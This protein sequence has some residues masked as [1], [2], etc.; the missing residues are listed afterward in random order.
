MKTKRRYQKRLDQTTAGQPETR[1]SVPDGAHGL[2]LIRAACDRWLASRRI[3][4]EK[5]T[6]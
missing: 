4:R 3:P 2:A 6:P 5:T 1:D